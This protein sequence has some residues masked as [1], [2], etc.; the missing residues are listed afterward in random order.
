MHICH[1]HRIVE[2]GSKSGRH[3][4]AAR[5]AFGRRRRHPHLFAVRAE[6]PFLR[7]PS[8]RSDPA[9]AGSN[10]RCSARSAGA[11]CAPPWRCGPS[12]TPWP[13]RHRPRPQLQGRRADAPRLHP[14]QGPGGD[15][16]AARFRHHGA[17]RQ[18]RLWARRM[19]GELVSATP[20]PS[21]RSRSSITPASCACRNRGCGSCPW[22]SILDA[23]TDRSAA[24]ARTRPCRRAG[25]I[26]GFI[27]RIV[28]QKK[29][30]ATGEGLLGIVAKRL[31]VRKF[32]V[33]GD[34]DMREDFA[35]AMAANGLLDR[36][37]IP[38]IRAPARSS[39]P[40]TCWSAPAIT[41]PSG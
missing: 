7:T 6:R 20:S 30:R 11:I 36:V 28:A 34:G 18:P 24:R 13:F 40:S 29:P 32:V 3:R 27:G 33:V 31:P 9:C 38:R 1:V 19:A 2:R 37:V 5:A 25:F 10:C 35:A 41:N 26:V 14:A 21:A 16:H 17:A 22:A 8:R 4:P 12:R 39:A 23:R 15:L